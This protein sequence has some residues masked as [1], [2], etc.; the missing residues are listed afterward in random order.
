MTGPRL[1]STKEM[2]DLTRRHY[3][4]LPEV[5]ERKIQKKVEEEKKTNRIMSQ[6]FAQV[7]LYVQYCQ[8]IPLQMNPI[9]C[10]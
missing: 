9:V 1:M 8:G 7:R 10:F 6:V 2:R 3:K 5:Q 4:K